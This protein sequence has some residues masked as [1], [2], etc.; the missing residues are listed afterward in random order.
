MEQLNC[1]IMDP[2]PF[3]AFQLAHA[4]EESN[5]LAGAISF[6][7]EAADKG[8][9]QLVYESLIRAGLC[10]QA[11]GDR[12]STAKD[13]Y[14]RALAYDPK[15]RE[16]HFLLSRLYEGL[17]DWAESYMHACIGLSLVSNKCAKP[18]KGYTAKCFEFQK[19][20][21]AWWIGNT[22]ESRTLMYEVYKGSPNL[23]D[24]A[25]TNHRSIGYPR[26]LWAY[27][28][29]KHKYLIDKF[30]GSGT[31]ERNYSQAAQDM[32]VLTVLQGKTNGT[33]LEIGSADPIMFNNTYL[34]E[35]TFGWTGYSIDINYPDIAK[36][37]LLRKN[38]A[39]H[40]DGTTFDYRALL[41]LLPK[42]IDYLQVDCEPPPVTLAI[43]K[44]VLDAG[45]DPKVITFEHDRYLFGDT[46][47]EESRA[48]LSSLGYQLIVKDV[49]FDRSDS[50][51][52]DWWVK[53][54]PS[55]IRTAENVLGIDYILEK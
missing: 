18:I 46:V 47:A 52:E 7:L 38:E 12:T 14:L 19:A 43:L 21:A 6:Y 39:I 26:D 25:F 44:R 29:G 41:G 37:N 36:F 50:P 32:F 28:Q 20:V 42:D 31:I 9:S 8:D 35:N 54:L 40:T 24:I 17:K 16:A 27:T 2:T 48:L 10:Y 15:A 1:Y 11:M 13:L 51:F 55:G 23:R 30:P 49:C 5:Q 53:N 4:L 34:L 22:E 3:A 45:F 33:Y